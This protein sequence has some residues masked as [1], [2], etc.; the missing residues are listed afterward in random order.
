M[1]IMATFFDLSL[2]PENPLY[3]RHLKGRGYHVC[4]TQLVPYP[5]G[6]Y[7]G[8]CDEI[9]WLAWSEFGREG[10]WI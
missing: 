2:D 5:T 8:L 3:E 6:Y 4:G 10:Q 1:S 7:C 9:G